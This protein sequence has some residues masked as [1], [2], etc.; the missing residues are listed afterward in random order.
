MG[1]KYGP[2]PTPKAQLDNIFI[3]KKWIN[4]PLNCEAYSSFEER[5]KLF[6]P[7]VLTGP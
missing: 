2:I 3:D 1:E 6:K 4:R 7:H 5:N